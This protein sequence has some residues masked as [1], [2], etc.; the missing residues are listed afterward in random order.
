MKYAYA[1]YFSSDEFMSHNQ[2]FMRF[3]VKNKRQ[4]L[5]ILNL[6]DKLKEM[7]FFKNDELYSEQIIV[8]GYFKNKALVYRE[9]SIDWNFSYIN[10]RAYTYSKE[11]ELELQKEMAKN[12]KSDPDLNCYV[13]VVDVIDTLTYEQIDEIF[14]GDLNISYEK[15][16][17]LTREYS[18]CNWFA[19]ENQWKYNL[20]DGDYRNR[21]FYP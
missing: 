4:V 5:S 2:T 21:S 20:K 17:F 18:K 11:R 13:D 19:L 3:I 14:S 7:G 1:I 6:F 16:K 10:E 15:V 8:S 12:L 9:S